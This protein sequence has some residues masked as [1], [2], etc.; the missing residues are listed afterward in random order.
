MAVPVVH[1]LEM[2]DV[3]EQHGEGTARPSGF[4]ELSQQ[5]S[6]EV[7]AGANARSARR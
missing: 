3:G 7:P 2:V 4:G 5:L 6:F 1:R